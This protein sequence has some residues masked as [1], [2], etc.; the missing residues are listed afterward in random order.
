MAGILSVKNSINDKTTYTPMTH[1]LSNVSQGGLN[2]I[3]LV[4]FPNNAT[5]RRGIY[6]F[7]PALAERPNAE[8]ISILNSPQISSST[9]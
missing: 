1:Q 9:S 5:T 2:V 3:R 6:A 4:N 7:N 8:R